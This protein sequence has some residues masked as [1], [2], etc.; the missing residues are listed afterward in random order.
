MKKETG[1]LIGLLLFIILITA[2]LWLKAT[3]EIQLLGLVTLIA[4]SWFLKYEIMKR[5]KRKVK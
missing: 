1:T 2:K 3:F 5:I 4:V